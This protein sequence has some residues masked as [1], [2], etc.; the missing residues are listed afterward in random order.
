MANLEIYQGNNMEVLS[1]FEDNAFQLI[2]IDPPF[3]TGHTQIRNRLKTVRDN[4]GDRT[5]FQGKRYKTIQLD[6]SSYDDTF[7]D[8]MA[9]IEPRFKEAYRLL[10]PTGSFFL[11]I[12]ERE[13]HYCKV[14]LDRIFGRDSFLNEIIWAYDYGARSKLKWSAKHDHIFWYAKSP[15]EYTYH[16]EDAGCI[17]HS[18]PVSLEVK[19]CHTARYLAMFGGTR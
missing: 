12:D 7:D 4:N 17:P 1:H 2:Y 3:N 10:T 18:P 19:E 6:S 13:S 9:F 15:Q 8:F 5:G 11:H 14:L 16:F